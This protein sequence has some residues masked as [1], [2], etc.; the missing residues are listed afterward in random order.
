MRTHLV[1]LLCLLPLLASAA[2]VGVRPG[3]TNTPFLPN[4][5]W[6]VHDALR[7]NPPVVT[8]GPAD[9]CGAAPSD[10]VVL[11]DGANLDHWQNPKGGPA[12]WKVENGYVEVVAKAGNLVSRDRFGD[13][14]IHLEWAAPAAVKGESQG[15]GNSGV[16]LMGQYEVQVVDSFENPTYADGQAASVYGQ[17]PPLANASRPPG[18][19]QTYDLI[20][21]APR[22]S[23]DG[24]LEKPA[25][26]TVLH[27]GVLAQHRREII[28]RG[29]HKVVATYAPHGP[30]GP[31]SLQ[32]HGN[33]V[34]YR[35]IWV[36]PLKLAESVP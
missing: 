34:R 27:N 20:F 9:R 14:Q 30:T 5:P 18:E 12:G 23:A 8:P 6:R 2:D 28:G 13:C 24:K 29:T 17:F 11:F 19:W 21:E 1:A 25:F 7:P 15:R 4:Q 26:V 10:A 36:R 31:L 32:D 35:N 16:F 22:F 33:P 3:Y